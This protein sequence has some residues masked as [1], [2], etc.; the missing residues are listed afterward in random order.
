VV[1]PAVVVVVA[2]GARVVV[3]VVV[4]V[5]FAHP[6]TGPSQRRLALAVHKQYPWQGR[7]TGPD[8]VVVDVPV[9]VVDFNPSQILDCSISPLSTTQVPFL[10]FV[11]FTRWL[12]VHPVSL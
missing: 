9:V 12:T 5:A 2:G 11:I 7:A 1:G 6:P 8:V 10:C 3:V 4:V